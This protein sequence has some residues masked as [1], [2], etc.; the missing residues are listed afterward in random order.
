MPDAENLSFAMNLPPQDAIDYFRQKGYQITWNWHEMADA[1]HAQAF[2]V[3]KA[4][5]LDILQ[6]I[7]GAVD[8]AI[9]S[10]TTLSDFQKELEPVLKAKGWWGKQTDAEGNTVQLGSPWRLETIFRANV[11]SA[12][13][14]GR[15]KQQ[16]EDVADRPYWQYVAV[17]DSRTRPEHA[18]LNGKT[19]RF[20]DPFWD[21]HYPPL[22]FR[23]RCRVRAL[24]ENQIKRKGIE[25]ESGDGRM[26]WEDRQAGKSDVT[27]PVCGYKDPDSGRTIFTDVG[28]SSNPGKAAWFPDLDRYD[29]PVAAKWVDGGL[30]GDDFKAFF[31]GAVRGNYPVAVLP[32]VYRDLIGAKS[33]TVYL[34]SDTL[35]KQLGR[36]PG[37]LGHPELGNE[38]Y[39]NFRI[40][41]KTRNLS[42]KTR[43]RRSFL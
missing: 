2:T 34:S 28:W 30:K 36:I 18:L 23:C 15:Y 35:D 9:S 17:M 20:D 3:A 11:Q 16:M 43:G 42:R 41:F 27:K 19:F 24:T 38:E 12:Y 5:R 22:G 10:G 39:Q 26:V 6:D 21:T 4:T 32:D 14:A 7:R 40:S 37:N 33:R 29:Y 13:M 31:A 25:V 8:K 1:A